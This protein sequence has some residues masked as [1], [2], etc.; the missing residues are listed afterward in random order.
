MPTTKEIA[1]AK[2]T[3]L[4][5]KGFEPKFVNGKTN[6]SLTKIIQGNNKKLLP[7]V[8]GNKVGILN[9]TNFSVAYNMDRKVPFF[10]AYNIDG[11]LESIKTVRAT[12]FCP[13]PRVDSNLQLSYDFYNLD[14]EKTE[15]EIGHMAAHKEMSWGSDSQTKAYQTFHFPNTVPQAERLNSGLW[16]SLEDYIIKETSK[17]DKNKKISVFTGPIL[18]EEDPF[19]VN[20]SSFKI[21]LLFFKVIVFSTEKGI[22]STA[23]I[24]SHEER[25]RELGMIKG[26]PPISGKAVTVDQPFEN[27]KYKKVFQVDMQLLEKETGLNFSWKGVKPI[28]IEN[29]MN[30]LKIIK[31]VKDAQDASGKFENAS[32]G[33]RNV[34]NEPKINMILS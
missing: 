20:D 8:E 19:Y 1:F 4:A 34:K 23:F 11:S 6:V 15:F 26:K 30:K 21:P 28:A 31:K 32:I 17:I 27:F 14:K 29:G 9:Y 16:R 10:T 5:C 33:N 22:F 7:K 3:L 13:D 12:A 2:A 24:M 25:L 18:K